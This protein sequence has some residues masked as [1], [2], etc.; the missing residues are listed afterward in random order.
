ML[1]ISAAHAQR[2]DT[3]Q[4]GTVLETNCLG[5]HNAAKRA[6]GIDLSTRA[7]ALKTGALS[8]NL[9]ESRLLAAVSAGRMPPSGRLPEEKAALLKNWVRS[10][11]AWPKPVLIHEDPAKRPLWSLSPV[12]KHPVPKTVFDNLSSNPVDRFVFARLHKAGLK[13]SPP[14]DRRTL[15]RRITVDVTGLPPTAEEMEAFLADRSPNAWERVVDRLLASPAYGERWARHW[16]DVVRYGESNGYEQNHVRP[17]AWPYRDYVIRSFNEDKPYNR[18]VT[19]QLAADVVSPNDPNTEAATGYLVAG[20]HDTVGI[21]EEEGT[22]QQRINDLEDMVSTT[23]AAFL[24]LTVGCARCHDHKFDPISQRDFYRLAAVFAGVRHGE[25]PLSLP[26]T[27]PLDER[28]IASARE[29]QLAART[30]VNAFDLSARERVLKL[31]G[32]RSSRPSVWARYNRDEFAPVQARF[33][34][35]TSLRTADG[36]QPCLDEL[37][38]FGPAGGGNMALASRGA[39]ATASS[40]LPGFAIHQTAHLNDGRLGNDFSWIPATS[41][42]E[43]AQI[44]LPAPA[45]IHAVVW[46]RDGAETP[47]FDDRLP[48]IYRIE[49]SL[50]GS[51]WSTVSTNEGRGPENAY[52]HPDELKASLSKEEFAARELLLDRQREALRRSQQLAQARSAYIGNFTKPE[53]VYLLARGDVMQRREK[54]APGAL[55]ACSSLSDEFGGLE[56]PE[57]ERRLA[58]ARWITDP[59]NPLTARVM[60]NRI[61]QHHFG[62]GIV[63]TPSDFGQNGEKPSHPELLDWLAQNFVSNGWRMKRLHRLILTSYIYRQSTAAN[64]NGMAKDAGN[65][66]IWRMPLQRMEAEVLRDAMLQASGALNRTM[67]GPGYRL[68]KYSVI[69]VAIYEPLET[70]SRDTWRRGIYREMARAYNDSLLA[71]F[72]CPESANRTPRRESTT[73]VLQALSLLNGPFTQQ[74][75]ELLAERASRGSVDTQI[76][77]AFR[78]ALARSP[79]PAELTE[80]RLL[81]KEAGLPALCRALMNGN[82]FLYY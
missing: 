16:L 26:K 77:A 72:D 18:F 69:N 47:R 31:R 22:R 13:P 21:Q 62:R 50:D 61:W 38:I 49:V 43:W 9:P 65:R 37:Q 28:Q 73:T 66:L 5:C 60:V 41:G 23:G 1:C 70:Y 33:I 48:T 54:V 75:A 58:L 27:S 30:A 76:S 44:E 24:G 56:M 40:V 2:I 80:A 14:A 7:A 4:A 57:P 11:A 64:R 59:R 29:E 53:D 67:Y 20:V 15:L 35:F 68:Y 52:V 46:S 17:N 19:E 55:S 63:G 79:S 3:R 39:K 74:Q 34:R 32:I 71:S 45:T 42:T 81:V 10:G 25:R 36:T 82:E 51:N 8:T 12:A 78:Y 6:G